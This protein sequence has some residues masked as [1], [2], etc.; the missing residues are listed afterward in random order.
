MERPIYLDDQ[1][2]SVMSVLKDDC[3]PTLLLNAAKAHGLIVCRKKNK[4]VMAFAQNTR[5]EVRFIGDNGSGDIAGALSAESGT[6]QT[7]YLLIRGK[8]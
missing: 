5:N 4:N 1:G 6:H 7:T 2:G 3:S 8:K